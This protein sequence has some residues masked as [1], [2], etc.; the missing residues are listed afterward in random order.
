VKNS[1]SGQFELGMKVE[2]M[3][4]L[5]TVKACRATTPAMPVTT[6]FLGEL[7]QLQHREAS[8]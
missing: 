6:I 5:K 8:G 2:L 4:S 1:V 7:Q 3:I